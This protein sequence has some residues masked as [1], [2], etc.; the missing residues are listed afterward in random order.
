MTGWADT[1]KIDHILRSEKDDDSGKN[2]AEEDKP[3]CLAGLGDRLAAITIRSS[4][5]VLYDCAA[6]HVAFLSSLCSKEEEPEPPPPPPP[7]EPERKSIMEHVKHHTSRAISAA[8]GH[9]KNLAGKLVADKTTE[10]DEHSHDAEEVA[11][12]KNQEA[13]AADQ[14]IK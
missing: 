4:Y 13:Q 7:P 2:E 12:L 10:H 8:K 9:A 1:Q 6:W 14:A 3:S 5:Q 11:N